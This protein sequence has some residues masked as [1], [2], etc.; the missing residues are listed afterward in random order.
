MKEIILEG[1]Y[2]S[3]E[4]DGRKRTYWT[5]SLL[6]NEIAVDTEFVFGLRKAKRRAQEIADKLGVKVNYNDIS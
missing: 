3:Y 2:L 6:D 5:I 1:P 4:D